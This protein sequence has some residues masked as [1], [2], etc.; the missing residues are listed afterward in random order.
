MS[1]I[2]V[3]TNR[4]SI[5]FLIPQVNLRNS[6]IDS[7]TRHKQ[8]KYRSNLHSEMTDALNNAHTLLIY[9]NMDVIST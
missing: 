1:S 5:T 6:I 2:Y 8:P 7:S 9:G 3:G 4:R